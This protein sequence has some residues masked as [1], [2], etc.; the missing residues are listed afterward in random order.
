MKNKFLPTA[1]AAF[2]LAVLPCTVSAQAITYLM[3]DNLCVTKHDYQRT[4]GNAVD[5]YEFYVYLPAPKGAK[6]IMRIPKVENMYLAKFKTLEPNARRI[7]CGNLEELNAELINSV[8][9]GQSTIYVI[10]KN[11]NDGYFGYQVDEINQLLEEENKLAYQDKR[12]KFEYKYD[13]IYPPN[14]NLATQK[15]KVVYQN[16]RKE[17]CQHI[18]EFRAYSTVTNEPPST[19]FIMEGIGIQKIAYNGSEIELK[20][21]NGVLLSKYAED[22]CNAKNKPTKPATPTKPTTVTEKPMGASES[23]FGSGKKISVDSSKTITNPTVDFGNDKNDKGFV[24]RGENDTKTTKTKKTTLAPPKDVPP[25]YHV[26]SDRENLYVIAQQYGTTVNKIKYWNNL[27]SDNIAI[28]Q[29][30]KVIDDGSNP[31]QNNNPTIEEDMAQGVR[32]TIHTAEQNDTLGSIAK[33]Y[34]TTVKSLYELNELPN[35]FVQIGQKIIISVELLA[36]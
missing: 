7:N 19:I 35:D 13:Q 10:E 27:T 22:I 12:T 4:K 2:A 17:Q 8:N 29:L 30:L 6:A 36:N 15:G 1:F 23:I 34:K 20:T 14:S 5:F 28:N 25:G 32:L 24:A 16:I 31:Y 9:I 26:V 33:R 11:G 3:M 18:R 21:V